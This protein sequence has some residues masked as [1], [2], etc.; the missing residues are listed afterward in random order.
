M[1]EKIHTLRLLF[2]DD[3]NALR[4]MMGGILHDMGYEVTTCGTGREAINHIKEEAFDVIML[5]YK[6][7]ELTGLN[8][9]QWMNEQHVDTPVLILTG[10]GDEVV[11]VEAMKLGAYDYLRKEHV[12]VEHMPIIINGVHE[13]YLFKRD[14]EAREKIVRTSRET[15]QGFSDTVATVSE[16]VE[17]SLLEMSATIERCEQLLAATQGD[18][19]RAALEEIISGLRQNYSVISFALHSVRGMASGLPDQISKPQESSSVS[20]PVSLSAPAAENK[21]ADVSAADNIVS[22]VAQILR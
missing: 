18:D 1:F 11:A 16:I 7:P 21:R 14:K 13:R 5:D 12:D 3:D 6:M 17:H 22:Q 9:L 10:A 19:Q 15:A 2:A 4:L 20:V 8:V